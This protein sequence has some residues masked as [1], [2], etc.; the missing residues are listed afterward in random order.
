MTF[1]EI[2]ERGGVLEQAARVTRDVVRRSNAGAE[3]DARVHLYVIT[4]DTCTATKAC[5]SYVTSAYLFEAIPIAA[6]LIRTRRDTPAMRKQLRDAAEAMEAARSLGF[7]RPCVFLDGAERCTV[8]E[9]RPSVCARHLVSSPPEQCAVVGGAVTA[10]EVPLTDDPR[11]DTAVEIA[12]GL[13]LEPIG[14]QYY[15]M[16][17]RM[18]LMCLEAWPRSDFV[19]FLARQGRAAADRVQALASVMSKP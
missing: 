19:P 4:C 10:I 14:T 12:D 16:L 8:Y 7:V 15:G 18:V 2:V 6:R 1:G 11:G 3:E 9:D 5:C 13:G 17:P